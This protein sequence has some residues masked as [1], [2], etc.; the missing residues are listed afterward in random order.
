MGEQFLLQKE[1]ELQC[2][3]QHELQGCCTQGKNMHTSSL[4]VDR[5]KH[6]FHPI[7]TVKTVF[8]ISFLACGIIFICFSFHRLLP[9]HNDRGRGI[10]VQGL[11]D[12]AL[13]RL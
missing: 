11:V 3:V 2:A 12:F 13:K 6:P 9:K 8:L 4:H 5:V 1:A 7:S 10:L